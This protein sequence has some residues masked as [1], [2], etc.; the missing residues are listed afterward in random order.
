MVD[1]WCLI[2][3]RRQTSHGFVIVLGMR[4]QRALWLI[5]GAGRVKRGAT[6]HK[7]GVDTS[8]LCFME[9]PPRR[10]ANKD[11]VLEFD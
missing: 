5:I 4:R 11:Y 10:D 6:T 2:S 9:R 3:S 7:H 1:G 8:F